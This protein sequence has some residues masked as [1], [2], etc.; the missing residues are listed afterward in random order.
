LGATGKLSE[1]Q[2]AQNV[3]NGLCHICGKACHIARDCSD[4]DPAKPFDKNKRREKGK[5]DA[6]LFRQYMT[7]S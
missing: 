1:E 4:R 6:K 7:A 3:K 2:K 5:K